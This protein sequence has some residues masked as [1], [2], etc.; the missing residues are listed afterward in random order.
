MERI[1]HMLTILFLVC[2]G[3]AN[4]QLFGGHIKT[5]R[6]E[7]TI[8]SNNGCSLGAGINNSPAGV[9]RGGLNETMVQNVVAPAGATVTLTATVT[10]PGAYTITTN[11]N[12][13]VSF[14]ASGVFTAPGAYTIAL[15]P[16]GTPTNAGNFTWTTTPGSLDVYGSVITTTAPLGS[17][18]TTHFNG[19]IG[20]AHVGTTWQ[21]ASQTTGETFNNNTT[22]QN[23]N[24]S[25]QGCGGVTTVIANGRTHNTVDI[26]GQCWLQ[27]NLIVVP[28]VYSSY[29]TNS[30]TNV[31]MTDQGYWGYYNT[32]TTDGSAG[33]S[34][35]EPGTNEG[36]MYQWCGAMN[37]TISERSR[38]I[39]PSGW[40]IPSDCEWMYLEHGQGMSINNQI[41][42]FI[43]A[44][45]NDNQG[46]PSYKLRSQGL[47]ATNASNFTGLLAGFR[48]ANSGSFTSRGSN[49]TMWT[50]TA[51]SGTDAT[52]R[53]LTVGTRG[54]GRSNFTK[55]LAYSIRCLKD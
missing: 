54:I 41:S 46:T 18:Y 17:T 39:C 38:G 26:N 3:M 27:S 49:Q 22:C 47:G 7:Y 48:T 14:A 50:S 43:R 29:G 8:S 35:T 40:H 20:S 37:A 19:I 51:T 23:K 25:A 55:G 9:R 44:D 53:N 15:N 33:W 16:T 34:A 21:N 2:Y 42:T 13:G 31:S 28:S 24:I 1:K 36:L 45:T 4:A 10:K 12:N 30:W 6:A 52:L 32:T 11:T 5:N